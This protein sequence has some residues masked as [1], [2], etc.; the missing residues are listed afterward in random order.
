MKFIMLEIPK[1]WIIAVL[2]QC[3]GGTYKSIAI[4]KHVN[5]APEA[6]I[7][8]GDNEVAVKYMEVQEFSLRIER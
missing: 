7:E 3:H 6:E 1:L 2:S 5:R 4:C 8:K